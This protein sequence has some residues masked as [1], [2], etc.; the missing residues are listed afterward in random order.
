VTPLAVVELNVIDVPAQTGLAEIVIEMLMGKE[1]SHCHGNRAKGS[2]IS[3]D[4]GR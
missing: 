2:M 1:G 3:D 4:T